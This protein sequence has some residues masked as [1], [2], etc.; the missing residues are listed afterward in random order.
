MGEAFD[1]RGQRWVVSKTETVDR[2][3]LDRRV[4]GRELEEPVAA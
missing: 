1:L 3:D 2:E 4:I